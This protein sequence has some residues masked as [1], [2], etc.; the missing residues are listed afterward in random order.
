MLKKLFFIRNKFFIPLIYIPLV[1]N[2]LGLVFIFEASAIRAT[3]FFNNSFY[4]VKSQSIWFLLGIISMIIFSYINY[5]NLYF[6]S[7]IS[8]IISFFLLIIVLIPGIGF[9]SGGARRWI[10]FG[11]FNLQPTE[12]SKFSIIVYLSSW[13]I[14]KEKNIFFSF[15][16]LIIS[17]IFLIIL[18]PD[19][20][21]AIIVFF[22]SV[23][24][25]YQSGMS[26]FNLLTLIPIFFIGFYLLVKIEPYRLNRLMAFLNP[27]SDPQG[28]GYH[29]NQIFISL[30]NGGLLGQGLGLSRQKY[31]FLPEA[32]TDSI[33]AIIAEEYGFLGSVFLIFL[34]LVLI[35]KIYHI[36]RLAPDKLARFLAT[37]IFA[38]FN[39]HILIN[40]GGMVGLFP[41][42]GVPLPFISYGGSNLIISYTLLGILINIEK[43]IRLS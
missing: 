7:F 35:Y 31:L 39:L 6:F 8:I 3:T 43:N 28:I 10:N 1:L 13:F 20:G 21:T 23:I 16:M 15:L 32:H 30:S 18:Q 41:L 9:E 42:T 26:L 40:I 2:L 33:F 36:I 17:L 29:I 27:S 34:Y 22:L 24:I 5:K 4:F 37:G 19:V 12:L 25:Y 14:R 11:F 38:F